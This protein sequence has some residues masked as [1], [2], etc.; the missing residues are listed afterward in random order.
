[1]KE[2][3]PSLREEISNLIN[4]MGY[5]HVGSEWTSQDSHK[6]LRIYIDSPKG[7]TLRDCSTVSHQLEALLD[8]EDTIQGRYL[9]EVSSPGVDRP[10]FDLG[11][12]EKQMGKRIKL[13]IRTPI[14]NR[15]NWTGQLLRIEKEQIYLLVD[16]EE[17]VVPF[18]YIEKANV[19]ADIHSSDR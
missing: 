15:R 13:R 18:C 1:M 7:I 6:V 5:E 3:A 16:E 11:Q 4:K 10:L 2:V 19:I 8:I 17:I 12:Y 9:L 14:K